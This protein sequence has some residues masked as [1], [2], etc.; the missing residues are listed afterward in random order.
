M[1][2]LPY[3]TG[4]PAEIHD[5]TRALLEQGELGARI[6]ARYPQR[7]EVRSNKALHA[8]VQALKAKSLK[9]AP[10]LGK[11]L[12]DDRL[13]VVHNAL[14]LHV[15]STRTHG[16][17]VR[18]LREVRI[19][20]LFKD[21]PPQFLSMIVAHELAHTKHADHDRDFYRLCEFLE[22]EYHQLELD[23]RLYLTAREAEKR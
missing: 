10:P 21:A 9:T 19:A 12:Y 8:Y 17:H 3:L 7:H 14:G 4:Y 20:S 5:R 18:K 16:S 11:V 1:D 13:H 2:P 15:T 22:P 6:A 23:L